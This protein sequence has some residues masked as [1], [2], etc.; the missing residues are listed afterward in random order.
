M[1]FPVLGAVCIVCGSC[2]TSVEVAVPVVEPPAQQ[3]SVVPASPPGP[4]PR[5]AKAVGRQTPVAAQQ[6]AATGQKAA[7]DRRAPDAPA[8]PLPATPPIGQIERL[9][10]ETITLYAADTSASGQSVQAQSL[11][12]P[13]P[14]YARSET[15]LRLHIPTPLGMQWVSPVDVVYSRSLS[16]SA[17]A[18][19]FNSPGAGGR[20]IAD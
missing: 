2:A 8:E 18:F 9:R 6:G 1:R 15:N 10:V 5:G 7:I 16:D 20:G 3:A 11:Q 17:P 19:R 12:L 13:I 14:V 4:P